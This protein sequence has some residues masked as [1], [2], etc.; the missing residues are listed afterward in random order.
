[1]LRE[2]FRKSVPLPTIGQKNVYNTQDAVKT[3]AAAL[4]ELVNCPNH[5]KCDICI[6]A[7]FYR[8][9]C[10]MLQCHH[11]TYTENCIHCCARRHIE[12]FT[13][14]Q[15]F[16]KAHCNPNPESWTN[17]FP[18]VYTNHAKTHNQE[19]RKQYTTPRAQAHDYRRQDW[20]N[21]Q[22]Q[23]L[24]KA[25]EMLGKKLGAKKPKQNKTTDAAT[26]EN[27]TTT[28]KQ[29]EK[30]ETISPKTKEETK[31]PEIPPHQ[32]STDKEDME[33]ALQII[34]EN[35]NT[36]EKPDTTKNPTINLIRLCLC[37]NPQCELRNKK[38]NT[39]QEDEEEKNNVQIANTQIHTNADGKATSIQ[40]DEWTTFK[41]ENAAAYMKCTAQGVNLKGLID[42]GSCIAIVS[43]QKAREITA[44]TDWTTSGGSWEKNLEL[45]AYSCTQSKLTLLGRLTIPNFS[46]NN[47]KRIPRGAAFWVLQNAS[48]ECILPGHWLVKMDAILSMH[49]RIIYYSTPNDQLPAGAEEFV[50]RKSPT[51]LQRAPTAT[52]NEKTEE[53]NNTYDTIIAAATKHVNRIQP[54]IPPRSTYTTTLGTRKNTKIQQAPLEIQTLPA[55]I[56]IRQTLIQMH[57]VNTSH[58]P[59]K[60]TSTARIKVKKGRN[61]RINNI[62]AHQIIDQHELNRTEQ[63]VNKWLQNTT[64]TQPNPTQTEEQQNEEEEDDLQKRIDELQG[65]FD[66]KEHM[67]P[68]LLPIDH[69]KIN[70]TSM[71]KVGNPPFNEETDKLTTFL[72]YFINSLGRSLNLHELDTEELNVIIDD[73]Q[74]KTIKKLK[75]KVDQA[76]KKQDI[77]KLY[78]H[79]PIHMC[80]KLHMMLLTA[81]DNLERLKQRN[82]PA[83]ATVKPAI[84]KHTII[85]AQA[86]ST[87]YYYAQKLTQELAETY[88]QHPYFYK[89][90]IKTQTFTEI[91]ME[92]QTTAKKLLKQIDHKHGQK[93]T[94]QNSAI[95][96][97]DEFDKIILPTAQP[98]EDRDYTFQEYK[99]EALKHYDNLN[100]N[101]QKQAIPPVSEEIYKA[102]SLDQLRTPE[103]VDE[104]LKYATSPSVLYNFMKEQLPPSTDQVVPIGTFLKELKLAKLVQYNNP[105]EAIRDYI[106][107]QLREEFDQ[108]FKM[109]RDPQFI[110]TSAQ[111]RLPD[112]PQMKLWNTKD[113]PS[114]LHDINTG[115]VL[116]KYLAY[117][118]TQMLSEDD[119]ILQ[120]GFETELAQLAA[121]MFCYGNF[122]VSLHANHIGL[123]REDVFRAKTLL[124][125]HTAVQNAKPPKSMGTTPDPDLEDKIEFM[126]HH[127]KMIECHASPFLTSMTAISKKRK[128]GQPIQFEKDSPILQH[129]LSLSKPEQRLVANQSKRIMKARHELARHFNTE[130]KHTETKK[131]TEKSHGE[132][133]TRG[134]NIVHTIREKRTIDTNPPWTQSLAIEKIKQ[135]Y[136]E[137]HQQHMNKT[138]HPPIH[139]RDKHYIINQINRLHN[140][141]KTPGQPKQVTWGSTITVVY[142]NQSDN[143]NNTWPQSSFYPQYFKT[144]EDHDLQQKLHT[145]Q[146]LG[147]KSKHLATLTEENSQHLKHK[148]SAVKYAFPEQPR[149]NRLPRSMKTNRKPP[150]GMLANAHLFHQ[151]IEDT[152][153]LALQGRIGPNH[154]QYEEVLKIS[155]QQIQNQ[156]SI[157]KTQILLNYNKNSQ[158]SQEYFE[159]Q[160]NQVGQ[161]ATEVRQVFQQQQDTDAPQSWQQCQ[162]ALTVILGT[163]LIHVT[164]NAQMLATIGN[165]LNRFIRSRK[166]QQ[167]Y[168]QKSKH[169]QIAQELIKG[170]WPQ[171]QQAWGTTTIEEAVQQFGSLD[172]LMKKIARFY[173]YPIVVTEGAIIK[174]SKRDYFDILQIKVYNA[175][176][177]DENE[178]LF[179]YFA[180]CP[181]SN[182]V[183]S[184]KTASNNII[185]AIIQHV[186][187]EAKSNNASE[188]NEMRQL[189]IKEIFHIHQEYTAKQKNNEANR[190]SKVHFQHLEMDVYWKR[191]PIRTIVNTKYNNHLSRESNTAFQS[192]NEVKNALASSAHYSSFDISQFYDQILACPISSLINTIL[193]RGRELALLIASMGSRNSC[194]WATV[195]VLTLLHHHNDNLILQPTYKPKP[196]ERMEM[197]PQTRTMTAQESYSMAAPVDMPATDL[198]LRVIEREENQDREISQQHFLNLSEEQRR[199]IQ[200]GDKH[201]IIH[202][203]NL[204]DDFVLGT[205]P[206]PEDTADTQSAQ[207]ERERTKRQLNIHLL[208]LKQ[209]MM[210][211]IQCSRQPENSNRPF[212]P[213]KYKIEKTQLFKQSVKFLNFIY[214]GNHQIIDLEAFKGATNLDQLPTTG[215]ALNSRIS[216][217]TYLIA[218]IE[219]LRYLV[220]DLEAF[221]IKYPNN[222]VLPW[223]DNKDLQQKYHNLTTTARALSGLTVLPNDLNKVNF[224]L[225]SS[226]SCNR[227]LGYSVGVS[228]L[229]DPKEG[230]TTAQEAAT[231]LK[232]VKNYSCNLE[233]NLLNLPIASKET[234]AAVKT[235]TLEEPLLKILRPKKVYHVIDNSVL[236][237]LLEQ[238]QTSKEL[239]NHFVTHTQFRDWVLRL[240]QITTLYNVT[241][242]LVPSKLCFADICTRTEKPAVKET[243][244]RA[245]TTKPKTECNICPICKITC[246]NSA[247]HKNCPYNIRNTEEL[248]NIGPQLI[249][250]DQINEYTIQNEGKKVKYTT[251]STRFNPE[252]YKVLQI[253]KLVEVLGQVTQ[254]SMDTSQMEASGKEN[255]KEIERIKGLTDKY[256]QEEVDQIQRVIEDTKTQEDIETNNTSTNST[257]IPTTEDKHEIQRPSIDNE[258]TNKLRVRFTTLPHRMF[259]INMYGKN[260]TMRTDQNSTILIFTSIRKAIRISKSIFAN[261]LIGSHTEKLERR[262]NQVTFTE[263][264][265]GCSYLVTCTPE[266]K[267]GDNTTASVTKN[268]LPQLNIAI[269]EAAKK[270]PNKDIIV[271][272]NSI[273]KFYK[274]STQKIMAGLILV[275]ETAIQQLNSIGLVTWHKKQTKD[276][277][278]WQ[279]NELEIE[280]PI[281]V[282]QTKQLTIVLKINN[283]GQCPKLPACMREQM[284]LGYHD[285]ISICYGH[286]RDRYHKKINLATARAIHVTQRPQYVKTID[287]ALT[288]NEQD[289]EELDQHRYTTQEDR[290][291]E[292]IL[293]AMLARRK[294]TIAQANDPFLIPILEPIKKAAEK[295][296]ILQSNDGK[297][298]LRLEKDIIYGRYAR[299]QGVEAEVNTWKPVL[300]E[301]MIITE[302][303]TAHETQRCANQNK[304]IKKVKSIFFHDK[305]STSHHNLHEIAKKILPCPRCKIRR[306]HSRVANKLY[307][308][309]KS[310]A[311]SLKGL[312]CATIAHDIVYITCPQNQNFQKKYVSLIVCYGCAFA[313]LKLVKSITGHNIASHI[314]EYIQLTGNTPHVLVTDS[315]T[316]E[317]RGILAQSI[318]TL[319]VIQLKNNQQ[320]L[321]KAEKKR[322]TPP[323]PDEQNLEN[324]PITTDPTEFPTV[325]IENLSQEQKD[326]LLQDFVDTAPPLYSPLLS[327]SPVPYISKQSY[328]ATSLGKLDNLCGQIGVFLRKFVT[329]QPRL[330]KDDNVE[331]L[332]QSFAYYHNFL[333]DDSRT[334]MPPAKVHLGAL[335]Y[336]NTRAFFTNFS[337]DQLEQAPKPI[338]NLRNMLNTA[339]EHRKAQENRTEHYH[340]QIRQH[341]ATHGTIRDEEEIQKLFPVLS[342]IML[343][344]EKDRT[345]TSKMPSLH[346]PHLVVARVPDKRTIYL[347]N[348]IEGH[349]YKRSFR[350][351]QELLPSQEL[352][353]TPNILDWFHF[354]PLQ[355]VGKLSDRETPTPELTENQYINVLKNLAKVYELLKPV[356]PSIEETQKIIELYDTH[357]NQN[358]IMEEEEIAETETEIRHNELEDT[359]QETLDATEHQARNKRRVDFEREDDENE[360][361]DDGDAEIRAPPYQHQGGITAPTITPPAPPEPAPPPPLEPARQPN[362]PKRNRVLPARFR[363]N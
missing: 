287:I 141:R 294:L 245:T 79:L 108:F 143:K 276:D 346:G 8:Q 312:P 217:L 80:H 209:L 164:E 121:L 285:H 273:Q 81:F 45:E 167:A 148:A 290:T 21:D 59:V 317:L 172:E 14:P 300:P 223:E 308:E 305:G 154:P 156:N 233:D 31:S 52:D 27:T 213:V 268:F 122:T 215:E 262:E 42:T 105:E 132:Q 91:P 131:Q 89:P 194:L 57:I 228:I 331:L 169:Q 70:F 288:D 86:L 74:H 182:E 227:T 313:H 75:R 319:N 335:R 30:V 162:K 329:T 264:T 191:D 310:I 361:A 318:K 125:P 253:E 7:D 348:L 239:A 147:C 111:L 168:K 339:N 255:E 275:S 281:F 324:E 180:V 352:L 246:T 34:N 53:D 128:L 362:R 36:E 192:Q 144:K 68:K 44:T 267:L 363:D 240:H 256:V 1:M 274:L 87:I 269:A 195:I 301:G 174:K 2:A 199:Q 356:L 54:V 225:L 261:K 137:K 119:V 9:E 292:P 186:A 77:T 99:A 189:T 22:L 23:A 220:K 29:D 315:A 212:Q 4:T 179:G 102:I 20:T 231:T 327:H 163:I 216:F 243:T 188:Q 94:V 328:R 299:D 347:F 153:N 55:K 100:E 112:Y 304:A 61:P 46:M 49:Q 165:T 15:A 203:V 115:L 113:E 224:V 40:F 136:I 58:K 139:E 149:K 272:G 127:G 247:S 56:Q 350:S 206:L 200:E 76:Y 338:T 176:Q 35:R 134:G 178:D 259:Q 13:N 84:L 236:F 37:K 302:I 26:T 251:A 298:Q 97:K 234:M 120:P 152:S 210:T 278:D 336:H 93:I 337:T 307:A 151:L 351:I 214:M 332:I 340:D 38:A 254:S 306:P 12:I 226:D 314:L 92:V 6:F 41:W 158:N 83:Q 24:N 157:R 232:L 293:D 202:Q 181:D 173:K 205:A 286:Q 140:K 135:T 359:Q 333:I 88:G 265:E 219:N 114:P 98:Y 291:S 218:Y 222:K 133:N 72:A 252:E 211:T 48:E 106:P 103:Q 110:K 16:V 249:K 146:Q 73:C 316:T 258:H 85:Q 270:S 33:L 60:I 175:N 19:K 198:L 196:I 187:E 39:E 309:H 78:Y 263:N 250:Y 289:D 10:I 297:I 5:N 183:F 160:I 221:A 95:K 166:H 242:L 32:Q 123:F 282:N 326:M 257:K 260:R 201:Q 155:T 185:K 96:N 353:S 280:L 342:I 193:Y 161:H 130:P 349:I 25:Y 184:T 138:W 66:F 321:E 330:L 90:E 101:A 82:K 118:T 62:P 271:D 311:M 190:Y 355:I 65:A 295:N 28:K 283:K 116:P 360:N 325:L 109:F 17:G 248:S 277:I 18:S 177:Y 358:N 229:P 204:I 230:Q 64:E 170:I 244:C 235:L 47:T 197:I 208:C 341:K 50:K 323:R 145:Y 343:H 126:L 150:Q 279:N 238:L 43:E 51:I 344:N 345:K 171:K 129:L 107:E 124:C 3:H 266:N 284:V 69:T 63:H 71:P 357:D 207:T 117:C 354:H 142:E 67:D 303:M 237:G 296:R 322:K 241:M 11:A 159:D 320:I 104:Y 334:K